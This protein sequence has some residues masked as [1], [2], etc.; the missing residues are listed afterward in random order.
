MR[1]KEEMGAGRLAGQEAEGKNDVAEA[2]PVSEF[3]WRCA[4]ADV[5]LLRRCPGSQSRY[6]GMGSTIVFTA[7]MAWASCGY[8]LYYVFDS[9]TLAVVFGLLWALMIF[10]LD[11]F[12]VNSIPDTAG[13]G[14][15]LLYG[16]PR[17]A[18]AV[19]IG[20]VISAPIEMKI[21]EKEI[22]VKVLELGKQDTENF[23]MTEIRDA[24]DAKSDKK[25]AEMGFQAADSTLRARMNNIFPP[26]VQKNIDEQQR[27]INTCEQKIKKNNGELRQVKDKLAQLHE[28]V[29]QD[30][31][32]KKNRF[33]KQSGS[34]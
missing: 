9:Q 26:E 11:R 28:D 18:M 20:I 3:L 1:D 13:T 8:A 19:L 14:V 17:F 23:A 2:N 16:L 15:R 24:D 21:F 5:E 22:S 6:T 25:K 12:I 29:S 10:S 32:Q 30:A 7:L 34:T 27:I 4:G 33:P 31:E